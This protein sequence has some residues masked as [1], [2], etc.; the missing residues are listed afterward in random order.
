MQPVTTSSNEGITLPE[1]PGLPREL[2]SA[3]DLDSSRG[4]SWYEE[5]QFIDYSW[6]ADAA[7]KGMDINY[8]FPGRGQKVSKF[9][10]DACDRCPVFDACL[11]HALDHED[12]GVWAKTNA[13][14]RRRER[15]RLGI[16]LKPINYDFLSKQEAIEAER[17]LENLR[18]VNVSGRMVPHRRRNTD[19]FLEQEEEVSL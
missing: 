2:Q 12:Y 18:K 11:Q 8:F 19:E 3:S 4:P 5:E 14:E 7:C 13:S 10:M 17:T 1:G 15:V 16:E 6:Q 9:V